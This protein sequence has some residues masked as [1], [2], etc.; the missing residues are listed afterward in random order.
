[1]TASFAMPSA[2]ASQLHVTQRV[3]EC[4][5]M[6]TDST[7]EAPQRSRVRLVLVDEGG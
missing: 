7:A 6:Q 4:L 2:V 5:S 3:A 1:M